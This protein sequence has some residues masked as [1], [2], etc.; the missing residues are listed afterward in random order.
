M[1]G[2]VSVGTND[3]KRALAYYDALMAKIIAY[4]ADRAAALARAS[5][6]IERLEVEGPVTNASLLRKLLT[7]PA[8]IENSVTTTWLEEQFAQK[9]LP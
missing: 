9:A 1:I 8:I 2:Y 3:W 7:S 4:G 6:A 5:A